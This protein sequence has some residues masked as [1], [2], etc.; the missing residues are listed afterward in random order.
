MISKFLKFA[1]TGGLGTVTNLILFF[2]FADMLHLPP[3]A[4]SIGCFIICASQ[5]Y[6]L[7]HL[8]TFKVENVGVQLSFRL[9]LK[10]LLSS[11][12]GFAINFMV[13][14]LLLHMYEWPYAVIPQGIGIVCG[15]AF[16]FVASL[17]FVFKVKR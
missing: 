14:N 5:N 10:F 11:L 9:W 13:M 3:S 12:I 8:W 7:N 6:C 4:V 17:F 16:N 2:I 15:M 1:V